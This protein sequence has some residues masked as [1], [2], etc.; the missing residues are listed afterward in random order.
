MSEN[1]EKAVSLIES[2]KSLVALAA[3]CIGIF[4]IALGIKYAA[5][6]FN[7]MFFILKQPDQLVDPVQ[8]LAG[9][10]GAGAYDI[11]LSDR[12]IPVANI[13]SLIIYCFGMVTC[14]FLTIS[15]MQ[16]GAKIISMTVG[17]GKATKQLLQ[18]VF[19]KRLQA[20]RDEPTERRGTLDR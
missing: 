16:A 9:V 11:K 15:L 17:D 3:T 8:R 19:G 4:V 1:E 5:E 2:L 18:S 14:A 6:I 13:I 12:T 10:I 7:L 20:L